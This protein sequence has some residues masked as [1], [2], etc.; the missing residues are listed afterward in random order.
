ML[1]TSKIIRLLC[2]ITSERH[3]RP[4]EPQMFVINYQKYLLGNTVTKKLEAMHAY[5]F[6]KT[7]FKY[8]YKSPV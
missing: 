4:I 8:V 6:H 7:M 5:I 3:F 1:I 2:I